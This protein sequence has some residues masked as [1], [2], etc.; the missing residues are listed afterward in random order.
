MFDNGRRGPGGPRFVEQAVSEGGVSASK[1]PTGTVTFLLTD[2]EGSTRR[3]EAASEVMG[4]A[5]DRHYELLDDAIARHGGLRP[6]EQGE[7]DSMVAAF[8]RASDAVAAALDG[9]RMLLAEPWPDGAE[10]RVRMAV[11]TGEVQLRG[12][13]NY[14]GQTLNRCA[15]LRGI[16]YGSQVLVSAAAAAVLGDRL[17]DGVV[18]RD[19]GLHRLRDLGRPEHVWQL[20]H[21][22]IPDEFG[23]LRSLDASRHNLPVQLS[24]LIG[25]IG[26]VTDVRAAVSHER[27]TTLVGSGGVGKTRLALAASAEL[28]DRFRGGVWWVELAALSDRDAIGRAVLAAVGAQQVG[29]LPLVRQVAAELDGDPTLVVLDNCEH[30]VEA[31]AGFVAELLETAAS[32]SVLATSREPLGVPGEVV[33]RVPSLACPGPD[34]DMSVP[35]V[36]QFDAVR[37][38]VD[39]A[40]RAR[41]SFS[42]GEGNAPA[43]AQI[44]HQL[45]GIPLAIELAAARCRQMSAERIAAELDDRFRYLTGGAR[46][47]MPRQRTLAASVDWSFERLADAER[48]VFRRLGVFAGSFPLETAEAV[49]ASRGDI[50]PEEVFDVLARLVDKSLVVADEGGRSEQASFRL[51]ET[52]RAY[53]SGRAHD[54]GELAALRAAHAS[55]WIDWLAPRWMLPTEE[56]LEVAD[57]FHT[58]LVAALTCSAADPGLGLVL[59]T[60]LGRIWTELG[61]GGDALAA[62]DRLLTDANAAIGTTWVTAALE[63]APLVWMAR[64]FDAAATLLERVGHA[65]RAQGDP[66][67][68][69]RARIG[70]AWEDVD[71]VELVM[72]VARELHDDYLEAGITGAYATHQ[73]DADP[74]AVAA[75]LARLDQLAVVSGRVEHVARLAAAMAARST[76]DLRT[77]IDL[78]TEVLE[79]GRSDAVPHA[80]NLVSTAGLLARDDA[81]LRLALARARAMQLRNPGLR[82]VADGVQHRL[83]QLDGHA[84]TVDRDLVSTDPVWPLTSATLWVLAR[85]AIDAGAGDTALE[86]AST[87]GYDDPHG[88]AVMASITGAATGDEDAWHTALEI[89][90]EKDLRLI[91]VDALEGLAVAA[92]RGERWTD[93]VR[94]LAAADRLR[95]EL[96]YRWRFPF[97]QSAIDAVHLLAAARL[98]DADREQ[99]QA[100]GERV[101]WRQVAASTRRSSG[102]RGD[103][104]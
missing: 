60:R 4:G 5:I 36:S 8:S 22:D 7:G 65:A 61:R 104:T 37:L 103:P 28:M 32:A 63:A 68:A 10:L 47:V 76:G 48:V 70:V 44:C 26:E 101:D 72:D 24:P 50:A 88:H 33:W 53:A 75:L 87:L 52:L 13:D 100:D 41:P 21:A 59:L 74:T 29:V 45:D 67:Y 35:A 92:G 31:C 102:R 17:P 69:A 80:V 40:R 77:C 86:R 97:E 2:V 96:G 66:Y 39:R 93:C 99:A 89:A 34:L 71:A 46:T 15:R 12:D 25:R 49:V 1:L 9:Q 78:A 83:D 81:A 38:F 11:H 85:E 73:A 84:S 57:Q 14:V 91:V 42:V 23:P 18:L 27:L 54:A 3:W 62:A 55:W 30:V 16:G 90:A 43:I 82:L 95:D 58:N 79:R 64:G 94:L 98:D 6:L 51:L 56:T 19:L 20:V